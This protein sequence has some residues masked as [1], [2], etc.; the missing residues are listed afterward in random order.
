[1]GR[2]MEGILG[3]IH[4][5]K[6]DPHHIKVKGG[7]NP[8]TNFDG[9]EDLMKSIIENGVRVPLTVRRVGEDIVLING[10]RRLRAALR[11]IKE[12]Y[13]IPFVPCTFLPNNSSD[14]E[15][16]YEM[17]VTN[18]GKRFEPLEEAELFRR[19]RAHGIST[20][21]IAARIGRS[22]AYV[23][24]TLALV[25]ASPEV[26][27]QLKAKKIGVG[28]ARKIVK[29]SEGDIGKQK[30]ELDSTKKH[31]EEKVES[32]GRLPAVIEQGKKLVETMVAKEKR[33]YGVGGLFD[34]VFSNNEGVCYVVYNRARHEKA[35]TQFSALVSAEIIEVAMPIAQDDFIKTIK[36]LPKGGISL[37]I[38]KVG[39]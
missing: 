3:S 26:R 19:L 20:K 27:E 5:I 29:K 31:K 1:M 22:E 12:G 23:N 36:K 11:C 35:I 34:A 33:V 4:M 16:M 30:K 10:E 18:D 24:R 9:E 2:H 32:R 7:W 37:L 6:V 39:E 25:N 17:Y 15:A 21:D 13:E 8:R 38:F 14:I 28:D